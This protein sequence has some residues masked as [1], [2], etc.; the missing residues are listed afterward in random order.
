[1]HTC[2]SF[3]YL[4][5]SVST[6]FS[7]R[8]E[9]VTASR[10]FALVSFFPSSLSFFLRRV[11]YDPILFSPYCYPGMHRKSPVHMYSLHVVVYLLDQFPPLGTLSTNPVASVGR[12]AHKHSRSVGK[13]LLSRESQDLLQVR[14]RGMIS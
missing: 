11:Y 1:M 14:K 8:R 7:L 12:H 4:C 2:P 6:R 3:V 5:I 9:F 10:L 13:L